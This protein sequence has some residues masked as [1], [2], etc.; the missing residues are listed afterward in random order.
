M[1]RQ[2]IGN[3]ELRKKVVF[4]AN[5]PYI[6]LGKVCIKLIGINIDPHCSNTTGKSK[7]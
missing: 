5:L 2:A 6:E 3:T 4:A 7:K 1:K